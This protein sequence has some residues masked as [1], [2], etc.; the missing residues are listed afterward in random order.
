MKQ[1]ADY[2]ITKLEKGPLQRFKNQNLI[3]KKFG[4]SGLQI[5]KA[6]TGKRTSNE[7]K[8]DLGID[9]DVFYSALS[10][11]EEQGML[12]LTPADAQRPPAPADEELE[13]EEGEAP[14][15]APEEAQEDSHAELEELP[16]DDEEAPDEEAAPLEEEIEAPPENED[17][18]ITHESAEDEIKPITFD[19]MDE[20]PPE[21][22]KPKGEDEEEP[23][24][25]EYKPEEEA[26]DEEEAPEEE[27]PE[28]GQEGD[29]ELEGQGDEL[30]LE[31]ETLSPVEK[32]IK[33]KYGDTGLRVY[34]L[35][36]GARTA[37]EIMNDTGLTESKLVEI[38]DFM[39]AQGIIKLD[40]PKGK[41]PPRGGK[42]ERASEPSAFGGRRDTGRYAPPVL[43]KE[44][45]GGPGFAPMIEDD[46]ALEVARGVSSPVEKPVKAPVDLIKSVQMKTKIMFKFGKKGSKVLEL[47]DGK[48]DVID[49][50][51]KADI[52][53]YT[54]VEVLSFLLENGFVLLKPLTRSDVHKK[55]GDDGYSVYK[56][57]GKEGLMLY[58]LIGK[59]LTIRQM[60]DKITKERA[61][62]VDM[63]IFIHQ[64]LGIELPIDKDVLMKQLELK[65]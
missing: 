46:D 15:E 10:F 29:I 39:D 56:V 35:I 51:L 22:E 21:D 63:F 49:I 31:D 44:K 1:G 13:I 54:V 34:A 27:Q 30:P 58:E 40:Y 20:E 61:M 4:E 57:Y 18:E 52:P 60:A 19:D 43:P 62:I 55:Y 65:G 50:A 33:D 25:E 28:G 41:P 3:L 14:E 36:D 32:I 37:E 16:P 12:E 64:V 24:P 45:S 38:L 59:E 48:N 5:Y 17:E 26:P 7:L 23:Q 42:K 2:R 11:M 53:L 9:D 8:A 6:I 47:I